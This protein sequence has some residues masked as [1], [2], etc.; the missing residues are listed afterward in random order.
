MLSLSMTKYCPALQRRGCEGI[1]PS[2]MFLGVAD[3]VHVDLE[4]TGVESPRGKVDLG[5]FNGVADQMPQTRF[6]VNFWN[7][8]GPFLAGGAS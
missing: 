3:Y 6:H 5:L 8:A 4:H 2:D 1:D 7:R